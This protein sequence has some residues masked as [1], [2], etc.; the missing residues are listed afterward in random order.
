MDLSLLQL[1]LR[2][3]S[4]EG[5]TFRI[6]CRFRASVVLF[7]INKFQNLVSERSRHW[8]AGLGVA[9][10]GDEV[11]LLM[12][13]SPNLQVHQSHKHWSIVPF[14]RSV[15]EVYKLLANPKYT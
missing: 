4:E 5:F 2:V 11:V 1:R 13:R 3:S 8:V 14:P 10:Y 12:K 7:M 6:I 15:E 9:E